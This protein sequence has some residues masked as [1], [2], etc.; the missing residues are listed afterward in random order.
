MDRKKKGKILLSVLCVLTVLFIWGNS[1]LDRD[2]SQAVSME[3]L[4]Q[5]AELA[6]RLGLVIEGTDDHWLRKLAHF[7]EFGLLGTELSL[8]MLLNG[9][10]GGQGI[11]NC[12][13]A[14]LLT[15]VADETIQLFSGRGSQVQ[16][17]LLDF[18]GVI[19][20]VVLVSA[21]Y[22]AIRRRRGP[23]ETK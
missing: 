21:V 3:L 8:L 1:L 13:F 19:T 14:G 7:G 12:L 11:A 2:E 23:K 15:A 17:V 22:L 18:S 20:A 10:F 5:I 16:D 4:R 9:A 6:E